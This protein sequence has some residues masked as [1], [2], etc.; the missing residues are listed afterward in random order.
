[1]S[2][3]NLINRQMFRGL[4]LMSVKN[5]INRQI[6]VQGVLLMSVENLFDSPLTE[7]ELAIQ[8]CRSNTLGAP[9]EGGINIHVVFCTQPCKLRVHDLCIIT[10]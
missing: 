10:N 6:N 5:L 4:L 2:V 3:K 1:M 7:E 9:E 8:T